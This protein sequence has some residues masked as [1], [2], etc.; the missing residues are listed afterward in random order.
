M[1]NKLKPTRATLILPLEPRVSSGANKVFSNDLCRNSNYVLASSKNS[2]PKAKSL[3]CFADY[4]F[5]SSFREISVMLGYAKLLISEN[6]FNND[7]SYFNNLN[8]R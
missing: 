4:R 5:F 6:A 1:F 3:S 2:R 7:L 8:D